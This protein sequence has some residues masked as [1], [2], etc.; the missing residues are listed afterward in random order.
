MESKKILI[1]S[2]TFS[3]FVLICFSILAVHCSGNYYVLNNVISE[4]NKTISRQMNIEKV[5]TSFFTI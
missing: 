3:V 1:A 5:K 2:A 4:Q